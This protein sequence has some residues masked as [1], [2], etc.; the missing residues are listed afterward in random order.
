MLK[1]HGQGSEYI[2]IVTQQLQPLLECAYIH[3]YHHDQLHEFLG[4]EQ[5]RVRLQSVEQKYG[6]LGGDEGLTVVFVGRDGGEDVEG[7]EEGLEVVGVQV[8][9]HCLHQGVADV[10]FSEQ[11]LSTVVVYLHVIEQLQQTI[12]H[13]VVPH[14]PHT[15][16]QLST[17]PLH[18]AQ[19][20]KVISDQRNTVQ[21]PYSSCLAF[22]QS[23]REPLYCFYF[24]HLGH[25][26]KLLVQFGEINGYVLI[27]LDVAGDVVPILGVVYALQLMGY[28]Q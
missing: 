23:P 26:H 7:D 21:P 10:V 3:Q 17:L 24:L 22:Q 16:L 15:H 5:L 19:P 13:H 18:F 8:L 14:I 28:N 4:L 2:F 6:Q 25:S 27:N 1:G 11:P 20:H 12:T 9:G